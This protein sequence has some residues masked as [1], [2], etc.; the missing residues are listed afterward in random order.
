MLFLQSIPVSQPQAALGFE[1]PTSICW[2]LGS[3]MCTHTSCGR[4]IDLMCG[5]IEAGPRANEGKALLKTR[6]LSKINL[7]GNLKPKIQL[8]FKWII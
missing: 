3:G 7:N 8:L 4:I 2:F 5:D 6:A 1:I